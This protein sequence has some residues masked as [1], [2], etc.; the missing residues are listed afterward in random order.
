MTFVE[1][2]AYC[3]Q[4]S[5]A[6]HRDWRLPNMKEIATL[7]DL[8]CQEDTWFHKDFF[9]DVKTTPLG[10]YWSSSTFAAT[11]GWGVNFQFGYDGYYAD[12]KNGRYPFRPVRFIQGSS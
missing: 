8:S 6:D 10:F 2:L 11:F 3:K 7:M 9:P 4:L 5:L 12:K 1:A